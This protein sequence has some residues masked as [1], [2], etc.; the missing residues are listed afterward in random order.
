MEHITAW[1]QQL[2]FGNLFDELILIAA[3]ILSITVHETCHGLVAYWLGD[4]TA[5]RA[6]RL[7]L[8]PLKHVDLGGLIM[9]AIVKFG[10]AKPVPIDPRYFR[11]PKA[12]MA[13]TALAG[14]LSNVILAL[15]ALL[16]RSVLYFVLWQYGEI[17]LVNHLI[18][19]CLYVAIISAGLAVFNLF[20]IP[21]LDG[22]KVLFS[23]LPERGYWWLMQ[24]EHYGMMLLAVLL[25]TGTLDAPLNVLRG[26]LLASLDAISQFPFYE[27]I[28]LFS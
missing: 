12:G 22:S 4:P 21:P 26:G 19:F 9:M 8:N 2:Q 6:G 18:T 15:L 27:L 5:K 14:P 7:T 23:L 13:L 10:W 20:P 28:K 17:E 3:A 24:Y 16:L 11:H 25:L 1:F